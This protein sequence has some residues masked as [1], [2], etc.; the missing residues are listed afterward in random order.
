MESPFKSLAVTAAAEAS[1]AAT[2][3]LGAHLLRVVSKA[4]YIE[5]VEP[6]LERLVDA[7]VEAVAE[8]RAGDPLAFLVEFLG[9]VLEA[10]SSA[11]QGPRSPALGGSLAF[12]KNMKHLAA[13]VDLEVSELAA[14]TQISLTADLKEDDLKQADLDA[15][16]HVL[17]AGGLPQLKHFRCVGR[18]S[19]PKLVPRLV[20]VCRAHRTPTTPLAVSGLDPAATEADLTQSR[21]QSCDALMVA[22]DLEVCGALATLRLSQNVLRDAAGAAL[23]AALARHTSL[24]CLDLRECGLSPRS[25]AALGEALATNTALTELDL[26]ANRGLRA[27]GAASLAAGLERNGTLRTL[28]LHGCAIGADGA[29]ALADALVA[30][31]ALE[32]LGL[33][34]GCALPIELLRRGG[35]ELDLSRRGL[36]DLSGLVL[37]SL[38][39]R[40]SGATAL[41]L[42]GNRL[43]PLTGAALADALQQ[44]RAPIARLD[45]SSNQLGPQGAA[46]LA[47]A[48]K[49]NVR[50]LPPPHL[51]RTPRPTKP[52]VHGEVHGE[53]HGAVH[54]AVGGVGGSRGGS[55]V[56]GGSTPHLLAVTQDTLT[57]LNL[58]KNGLEAAGGKAVAEALREN[59][60]LTSLNLAYNALGAEGGAA[61]AGSLA[62]HAALTALDLKGNQ[63]VVEAFAP[64]IKA[65]LVLRRLNLRYNPVG[66]AET[67]LKEAVKGRKQPPPVDAGGDAEDQPPFELLL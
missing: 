39:E 44:G 65:N 20:A 25:A 61:L 5:A 42:N 49:G 23:G 8:Q 17:E 60:T 46:A 2:S 58:R 16:G 57:E 54:G 53:V 47:E 43:G 63:L 6:C 30:N 34:E 38:V 12:T 51:P 7:A 13:R 56:G 9:S 31:T 36:G 29:D 19:D 4:K 10:R 15:L 24:T 18:V 26:G 3:V 14:A 67:V 32:A 41:S 35:P 52:G 28:R 45:L 37:A 66:A 22:A 21:L 11:P 33:E 64:A 40:N 48:L 27:D 62:S 50:A 55:W 59:A 1:T